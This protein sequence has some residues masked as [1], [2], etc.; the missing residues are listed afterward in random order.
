MFEDIVKAV[1]LLHKANIC[2]TQFQGIGSMAFSTFR[3]QGRK[4]S[5][6]TSS[7]S[8]PGPSGVSVRL[9]YRTCRG[10]DL[11]ACLSK[12]FQWLTKEKPNQTN[13]TNKQKKS[14]GISQQFSDTHTFSPRKVLPWISACCFSPTWTSSEG[15]PA[16]LIGLPGTPLDSSS[17]LNTPLQVT[18]TAIWGEV[19]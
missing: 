5:L 1:V 11:K 13:E 14:L 6:S 18:G 7:I 9:Y 3:V 8:N 16:S 4:W 2:T 12:T 15:S 17:Y 19:S 10:M